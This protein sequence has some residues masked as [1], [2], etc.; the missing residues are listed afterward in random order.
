MTTSALVFVPSAG[1]AQ[2]AALESLRFFRFRANSES[3]SASTSL[4][5]NTRTQHSTAATCLRVTPSTSSHHLPYNSEHVMSYMLSGTLTVCS[6]TDSLTPTLSFPS[7]TSE[8]LF[9]LFK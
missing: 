8:S 9:N 2:P 6:S 1:P 7:N 5:T 3:Y 4:S